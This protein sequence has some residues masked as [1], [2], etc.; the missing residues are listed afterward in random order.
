MLKILIQDTMKQPELGRKI[1][2]LRRAKNLTQEELVEKCNI[3]VRTIQRIEA[4]EVTPRIYTIKTILHALD[5][6]ISKLTA[7]EIVFPDRILI[8]LKRIFLLD[9]D[10][11]KSSDFIIKQLNLAWMFGIAYF[12]IGFFEGAAEYYRYSEDV[13]IFSIP[14]YI[15]IKILIMISFFY[16]QRAFI[17]IGSLFQNY[18]LKIISTIIIVG[19]TLLCCYDIASFFYNGIAQEWV[20]GG[21]ALTFGTIGI[22]YGIGLN[23]LKLIGKIVKF[24]GVFE[25]LA[26]C[27]FLTI[28]MSFIGFILLIP[29]NIFEIIILFKVIELTKKKQENPEIVSIKFAQ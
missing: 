29:A 19:N 23:K 22:I 12:I 10:L 9:L 11:D 18:L 16:F 5:Y 27:F 25:I 3:S 1:L 2:E 20:M 26:G 4:G 8:K 17:M 14:V 15:I 7:N 6:D 24:A 21:V 28:I 13:L